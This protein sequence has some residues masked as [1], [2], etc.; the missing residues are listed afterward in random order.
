MFGIIF[1]ILEFIG[2]V[3]VEVFKKIFAMAILA[4]LFIATTITLIILVVYHQVT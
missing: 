3:I 1:A 4:F 2:L